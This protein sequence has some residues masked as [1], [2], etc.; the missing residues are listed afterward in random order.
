MSAAASVALARGVGVGSCELSD[1][2]PQ[3]LFAIW[4]DANGGALVASHLQFS[5]SGVRIANLCFTPTNP[6]LVTGQQPALRIETLSTDDGWEKAR[7]K[8]KDFLRF[9]MKTIWLI[10]PASRQVWV[11]TLSAESVVIESAPSLP[12][13]SVRAIV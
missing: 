13:F 9:G 2:T 10:D 4:L 5:S 12:G 8:L 6:I 7:I 1:S 11:A 3:T